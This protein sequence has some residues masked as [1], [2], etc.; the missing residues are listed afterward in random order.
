MKSAI[1]PAV[2][3]ALVVFLYN[4]HGIFMDNSNIVYNYVSDGY[5][6]CK[7]DLSK[8]D[9]RNLWRFGINAAFAITF[10]LFCWKG[11]RSFGVIVGFTWFSIQAMEVYYTGNYFS[12]DWPDWIVL[13]QLL[14]I[15]WGWVKFGPP[16]LRVVYSKFRG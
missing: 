9:P 16:L 13:Q 11:A 1:L 6:Y 15:W 7:I 4:M 8:P 3:L 14:I 2:V 5:Q 10:L 12:K